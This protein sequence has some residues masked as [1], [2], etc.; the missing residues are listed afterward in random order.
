VLRPDAIVELVWR[1]ESG[2]TAVTTLHAPSSLTVT[3][4]DASATAVA[5][6]LASLTDCVLIGQRIRYKTAFEPLPT[7][8]NSTPI[9]RV[10][11][12][13]FSTE[14]DASYAII[15][16]PAIKDAILVESGP[17]AGYAINLANSDVIAF[18]D[19]V[20]SL[21]FSNPFADAVV[22]LLAAYLQSRV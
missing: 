5:S 10:G 9:T 2:S 18:K 20:T 17:T 6:I 13:F 11:S 19:A 21:P 16:I 8:A 7:L 15:T 12:F 22:A 3:E 4:I 1:D 14:G